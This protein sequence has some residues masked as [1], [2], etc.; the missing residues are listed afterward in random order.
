MFNRVLFAQV[1]E[2]QWLSALHVRLMRLVKQIVMSLKGPLQEENKDKN[3][4]NLFIIN[5]LNAIGSSW[6]ISSKVRS[7]TDQ[8]DPPWL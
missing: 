4:F 2:K 8:T 5:D 6:C 7:A 1:I 3:E